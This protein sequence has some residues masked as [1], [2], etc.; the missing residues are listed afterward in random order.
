MTPEVLVGIIG[1]AAA[2]LGAIVGGLFTAWASTRA[3]KK[4]LEMLQIQLRSQNELKARELMFSVYQKSSE[5]LNLEI[6]NLGEAVAKVSMTQHL[7]N[8]DENEKTQGII[9]FV[10]A[11]GTCLGPIA[12]KFDDI[13]T[14]LKNT[15]LYKKHQKNFEFVKLHLT[16][17]VKAIT[18]A[19]IDH[20]FQAYTSAL[21]YITDIQNDLVQKKAQDLFTEY[22]PAKNKPEAQA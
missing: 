17:D 7:P 15:G 1:A 5:Q 21:A 4:Q 3:H 9:A 11:I 13:E 2:L 18:P 14:E 16:G 12:G 10:S 19:E 8:I 6:K 22:L 20:R